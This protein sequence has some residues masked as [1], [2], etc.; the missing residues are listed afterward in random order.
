MLNFALFSQTE[1][2]VRFVYKLFLLADRRLVCYLGYVK[3]HVGK[4][5]FQSRTGLLMLFLSA[6]TYILGIPEN[7]Y[8]L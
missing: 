4:C 7:E 3:I 6:A 8:E 1:R 2:P 5:L